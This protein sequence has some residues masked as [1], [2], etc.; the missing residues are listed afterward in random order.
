MI[1]KFMLADH[2]LTLSIWFLQ[3]PEKGIE[4][5]YDGGHNFCVSGFPNDHVICLL[6]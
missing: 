5:Q 3:R 4:W 2:N 1:V 6:Q